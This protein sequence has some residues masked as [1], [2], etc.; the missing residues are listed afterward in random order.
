M[1]SVKWPRELPN[2]R[3][4]VVDGP[5]I[6]HTSA[7]IISKAYNITDLDLGSNCARIGDD[8]LK[9]LAE[10]CT[11][12]KRIRMRNI[13][14]FGFSLFADNCNL[15]ESLTA[16]ECKGVGDLT[17]INLGN[18]CRNLTELDV[19][20]CKGISDQGL[21]GLCTPGAPHPYDP[22]PPPKLPSNLV[23]PGEDLR[24]PENIHDIM[25]SCRLTKLNLAGC[26][27]LTNKGLKAIAECKRIQHLNLNGLYRLT[28]GGFI[29]FAEKCNTLITLDISWCFEVT[30]LSLEILINSIPPLSNLELEGCSNLHE[31]DLLNLQLMIR[32]KLKRRIVS[33]SAM[34]STNEKVVK[35]SKPKKKGKAKKPVPDFDAILNSNDL[36]T[37]KKKKSVGKKDK[38]KSKGKTKTKTK[39]NSKS[40]PEET[41]VAFKNI[42]KS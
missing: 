17:L 27:A 41:Y 11:K 2:L 19:S 6:D 12:L 22:S 1:N 13:S 10:T 15:L 4:L 28:D 18:K 14:H 37:S 33:N 36:S 21:V 29:A 35:R 16:T 30:L 7:A 9:S 23:F 3:E 40:D 8:G 39:K 38:L 34:Q 25:F 26:T 24:I 42:R 32:G 31:D 5:A 20:G